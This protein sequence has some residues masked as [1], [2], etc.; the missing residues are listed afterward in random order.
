ML[1]CKAKFIAASLPEAWLNP[2]SPTGQ[3]LQL[4]AFQ[5]QYLAAAVISARWTSD[6]RRHAASALRALVKLRGVP[7][8]CRFP[9]AQSHLWCFAFWDSHDRRLPKHNYT[10]KQCSLPSFGAQSPAKQ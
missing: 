8:V 9:R 6:V 7:A 10:K 3:R 4:F 1:D 5:R 2:T